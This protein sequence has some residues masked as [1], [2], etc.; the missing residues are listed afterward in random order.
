MP[1]YKRMRLPEAYRALLTL[2][3]RGFAWEWVRRNPDFRAIWASAGAA[4]HRTSALA[5][6]AIRRSARLTINLPQHPLARRWS[7]WG[8]TF[9][10]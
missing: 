1:G 6:A 7:H 5:L 10:A 3:A 8:L 4:A 9:R 2:N